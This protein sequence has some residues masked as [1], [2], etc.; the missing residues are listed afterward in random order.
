MQAPGDPGGEGDAGPR[1][2]GGSRDG[3]EPLA[4]LAEA[5]PIPLAEFTAG[6]AAGGIEESPPGPARTGVTSGRWP[7]PAGTPAWRPGL[8]TSATTP[9]SRRPPAVER[10]G[11]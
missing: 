11:Y 5:P 6:T 9:Q 10:V 4:Q 1:P 7:S 2:G 8:G 3:P